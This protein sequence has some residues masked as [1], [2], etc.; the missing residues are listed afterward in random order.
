MTFLY[1]Y[2]CTGKKGCT[3]QVW[4]AP[5]RKSGHH[6]H[7]CQKFNT[8]AELGGGEQYCCKSSRLNYFQN[9]VYW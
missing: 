2:L 3:M 4:L 5:N 6:F 1:I 7:L 9:S 8:W